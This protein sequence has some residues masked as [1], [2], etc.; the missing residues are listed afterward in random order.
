VPPLPRESTGRFVFADANTP[1]PF[2]AFVRSEYAKW[3]KIIK[4]AK[5]KIE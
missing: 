3:G 5:I 2:A 4:T 1:Y